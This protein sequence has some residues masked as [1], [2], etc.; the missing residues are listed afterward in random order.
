ME[1]NITPISEA[2]LYTTQI[3]TDGVHG[4][5]HVHEPRNFSGHRVLSRPTKYFGVTQIQ[6]T[7]GPITIQFEISAESLEEAFQ[8]WPELA[9]ESC[10]KV[11]EDAQSKALRASILNPG[12][13]PQ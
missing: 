4:Q 6:T 12:K 8:L 11:L 2:D 5:L 10:E 7:R 13:K 9:K 3:F 1:V